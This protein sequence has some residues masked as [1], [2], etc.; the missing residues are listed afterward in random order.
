MHR[1]VAYWYVDYFEKFFYFSLYFFPSDAIILF[2]HYARRLA[3]G[4]PCE[5]AQDQNGRKSGGTTAD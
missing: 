2:V 1:F 3:G 4:C 5:V